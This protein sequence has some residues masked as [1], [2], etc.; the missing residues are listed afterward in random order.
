[1]VKIEKPV[2]LDMFQEI[3]NV[4]WPP[5]PESGSDGTPDG[6]IWF[7]G[8]AFDY[9]VGIPSSGWS[10][11][12]PTN[13]YAYYG[14]AYGNLSRSSSPFYSNLTITGGNVVDRPDLYFEA[15]EPPADYSINGTGP[16]L[17][18][19]NSLIGQAVI[20]Q[21]SLPPF[22][23]TPLGVKYLDITVFQ[24]FRGGTRRMYPQGWR[25]VSGEVYVQEFR[26]TPPDWWEEST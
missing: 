16:K 26:D 11:R 10:V 6:E 22:N 9:N 1:M 13:L 23:I 3:V 4:R 2:R 24:T 17:V 15:Y 8:T 14:T 21:Y 19:G 7:L 5:D 18:S 20:E 25:W 12:Q